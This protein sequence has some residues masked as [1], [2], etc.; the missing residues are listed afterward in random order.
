MK[1]FLIICFIFFVWVSTGTA[2]G[3]EV[4]NGLD[5]AIEADKRNS[6]FHNFTANLEMIL[7]NRH[8]DESSRALNI[9][10][11]EVENDGDKSLTVFDMP[12]D[13]RGSAFLTFSHK[14]E[15]DDRWL[16][17]PK[18]K[19][20]KR[21]NSKN[22]SG[23]FM[24]SEFSYEDIASQEVEKYEYKWIRN[25]LLET[26][27]CFVFERH[28]IDKK[29]SGYSFQRVWMDTEA[30][31]IIKIDYYDKKN[32]LLKTLIC[33]NYKIYLNHFWRAEK[34]E[35]INHQNGKSTILI[36]SDFSFNTGLTDSDFNQSR[37]PRSH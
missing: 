31:R 32:I 30:Y 33:S 5:I 34:M 6:G 10:T 36:W 4:P 8:G 11:L 12:K 20:V 16:Y 35:M 15:D 13:I 23:S 1:K 9:K 29:N 27:Q 7:K 26:Y 24:G 18:L 14:T 21:I 2:H 19:R 17:L 22:K 25:E 3:E 28:P 37:L